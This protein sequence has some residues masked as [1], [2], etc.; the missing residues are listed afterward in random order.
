MMTA[1]RITSRYSCATRNSSGMPKNTRV[2]MIGPDKVPMPPSIK[3][4]IREMVSWALSS[5]GEMK[6]MNGA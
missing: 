4:P 6:L 2:P 3:T 1:P 5:S